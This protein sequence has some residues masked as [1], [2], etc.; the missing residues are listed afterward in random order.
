MSQ[1]GSLAPIPIRRQSAGE[2]IHRLLRDAVIQRRLAPATRLLEP[3]LAESLSV[4]RTPVRE[5]LLRLSGEKLVRR[6][7]RGRLRI[8]ALTRKRVL[9]LY[10][11]R[12]VLEGLAARTAARYCDEVSAFE[13]AE[14]NESFRETGA[15]A[16]FRDAAELNIRF[17]EAVA[18]AGRNDELC[19]LI[20]DIHA[21]VRRMPDTTLSSP[22][23]LAAA[24]DEHRMMIDAIVAR[25]GERA[26]RIAQEHMSSSLELRL[27]MLFP[28]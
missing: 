14:M 21:W 5:A 15:S 10:A 6:D 2:A 19:D 22:G 25:D 18:R 1:L 9:D 13:L 12:R 26:D 4:S 27:G 3:E 16:R 28:E 23:R 8:Q 7:A 11:I 17:H 24:Y 20:A